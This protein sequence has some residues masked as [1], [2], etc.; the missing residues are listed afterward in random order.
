MALGTRTKF[1]LE[2]ITKRTISDI[3]KFRENILESSRYVSETISSALEADPP[4]ASQ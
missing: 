4:V 3:Y 1:Q 2:I